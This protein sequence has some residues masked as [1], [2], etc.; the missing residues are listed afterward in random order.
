MQTAIE[1]FLVNR[2]AFPSS[3]IGPERAACNSLQKSLQQWH[4]V[5]KPS[6]QTFFHLRIYN[7]IPYVNHFKFLGVVL[8]RN[9]SMAQHVKYIK[10]KCSNRLNLFRCLTSSECGADRTTLLRLYKAIVLPV[11]KY[12]ATMCAGGKEKTLASLETAQNS[13]L[14]IALGAMETS[15]ISAL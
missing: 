4:S 8:D 5:L 11:I 14:R 1:R 3:K 10:A 13:F 7:D 15:P 9:L 2:Q 6:T 12:G